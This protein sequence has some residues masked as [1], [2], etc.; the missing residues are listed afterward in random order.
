MMRKENYRQGDI[1]KSHEHKGSIGNK[2]SAHCIQDFFEDYKYWFDIQ[3]SSTGRIREWGEYI[4]ISTDAKKT[5]QKIYH[6]FTMKTS[7]T[8]E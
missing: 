5:I 8:W 1:R 2:S 4:F 3:K 6:P 7:V